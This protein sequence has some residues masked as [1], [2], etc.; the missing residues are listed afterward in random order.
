MSQEAKNPEVTTPI[1]STKH[2]RARETDEQ[3]EATSPLLKTPKRVLSSVTSTASENLEGMCSCIGAIASNRGAEQAMALLR[4]ILEREGSNPNHHDPIVF[5]KTNGP[6][7]HL[8]CALNLPEV[9]SLLLYYGASLTQRFEGSNAI[10]KAIA[11][12]NQEAL[13]AIWVYLD[14][15]QEFVREQKDEE[16][17]KEG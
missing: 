9:A 5:N 3:A 14:Q 16:E 10:E 2:K 12:D 1:V 7:L 15:C 4:E 17:E 8:A 13:K 6:P 11:L